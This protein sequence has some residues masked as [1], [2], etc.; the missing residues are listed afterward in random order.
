M[1]LLVIKF[2][3]FLKWILYINEICVDVIFEL[4]IIVFSFFFL[5]LMDFWEIFVWFL[6]ICLVL[7]LLFSLGEVIF[8]DVLGIIKFFDFWDIFFFSNFFFDKLKGLCIGLE[9]NFLYF[10]FIKIFVGG[11]FCFWIGLIFVLNFLNS[12]KLLFRVFLFCNL[13]RDFKEGNLLIC[14]GINFFGLSFIGEKEV[15]SFWFKGKMVLD[16]VIFVL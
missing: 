2:N 10:D 13:F 6:V 7:E 8:S 14:F 11:F 3:V 4:I 16:W 15:F 1:C 12:L 5:V 9:I